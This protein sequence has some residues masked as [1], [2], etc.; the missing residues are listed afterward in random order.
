MNNEMKALCVESFGK[1][2]AVHGEKAG[3]KNVS[4]REIEEILVEVADRPVLGKGAVSR[5]IKDLLC[6]L[7]NL[8]PEV[9]SDLEPKIFEIWHAKF[10][11]MVP[12][13]PAPPTGTRARTGT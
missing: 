10:Q 7:E 5:R 6:N 9:R 11:E 12:I 8:R 13:K 2:L 1:I 3:L 4:D